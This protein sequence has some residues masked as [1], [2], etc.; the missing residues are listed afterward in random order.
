MKYSILA[1]FF[2]A[3]FCNF[4]CSNQEEVIETT[5]KTDVEIKEAAE[6]W[7]TGTVTS[8]YTNEGC[9]F[10]IQLDVTDA[11][12]GLI[13]PSVLEK[14]FQKNGMRVKLKFQRTRMPQPDECNKGILVI[15]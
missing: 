4:G 15:L 2:L 12:L 14:K 7:V 8:D 13:H 5:E 10:L 3:L 1:F 9:G 11:S 6:G